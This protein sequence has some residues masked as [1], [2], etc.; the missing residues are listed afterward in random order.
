MTSPLP[1]LR[2]EGATL[3]LPSPPG[4]GLR[5]RSYK[6][7]AL[8]TF[9]F[10]NSSYYICV[11]KLRAIMKTNLLTIALLACATIPAMAQTG[12]TNKTEARNVI[13]N[14][15]KQGK[16][17]EYIDENEDIS[18]DTT[19]YYRLT[20]YKN[21]VPQGVVREYYHSG[22]LRNETP[23]TDG[24]IDGVVKSYF[25]NGT[26]SLMTPYVYG[27]KEGIERIYYES[28]KIQSETKYDSGL[29]E[30]QK[31]YNEDGTEAK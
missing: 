10:I 3:R 5:M 20:I 29:P 21:D 2:G 6:L 9:N 7:S 25:E 14:S 22:K 18:D 30:Y 28:G 15:M 4:E 13:D 24:H 31:K 19:T 1:T 17:V 26:L 12:F 16:W 23:Y 27:K 11:T 8:Q